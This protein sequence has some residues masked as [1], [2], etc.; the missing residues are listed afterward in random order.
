MKMTLFFALY[1]FFISLGV[2][3]T[4]ANEEDDKTT[5]V[6]E[7]LITKKNNIEK[8]K[9][10]L[11]VN[12]DSF[13]T[14]WNI[15]DVKKGQ[16]VGEKVLSGLFDWMKLNFQNN[17]TTFIP[18]SNEE[19]SDKTPLKGTHELSINLSIRKLNQVGKMHNFSLSFNY[20]L[21]NYGEV[22]L[23]LL[24]GEMNEETKSFDTSSPRMLPDNMAK[25]ILVLLTPHLQKVRQTFQTLQSTGQKVEI[26]IENYKNMESLL[27]HIDNL[28]NAISENVLQTKLM[29]FD[30]KSASIQIVFQGNKVNL[31]KS[32]QNLKVTDHS[33]RKTASWSWP[34]EGDFFAILT[35][36]E[37]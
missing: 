17:Q 26:K 29:K 27:S 23:P 31:K 20:F 11:K 4:F 34:V 19:G 1:F 21:S 22:D 16:G 24:K 9:L 14:D 35:F 37:K 8:V 13:D 5:T 30:A 10:L 32:L 36:P 6:S 25:G 12:M 3:R 33:T 15:Y 28:K 2:V 18:V 7:D